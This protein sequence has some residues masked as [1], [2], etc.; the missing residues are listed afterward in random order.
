MSQL[1]AETRAD[2][3][4]LGIGLIL[5]AFLCFAAVDTSVKWL[6]LVGLPAMQL[7]FMRYLVAF[8]LSV[9]R[10]LQQG[11]VFEWQ[12]WR[13]M[14]LVLLRGALLVLATAF[15]F[16]ALGYLPLSV[17]SSILNSAP[18]I[19]TALAVP[20]LG[21]RVG[22]FRWAAVLIGFIGVLI[23]IRPF[24]AAFH[25]ATLLMVVNAVAMAFFAILTRLLSGQI[26][27]QTMQVYMG[28]LGTGVLLVPALLTWQAPANSFEW[29]LLIAVGGFAW[30]GHE[31]YGRAH[32]FAEASVLIPFNYS[33][34]V[35]LTIAGVIVFGDVPDAPVL[36]GAAIIIGSGLVIWWRETRNAQGRDL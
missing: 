35:Y 16:I 32:A 1:V 19:L 15:N 27:T 36:I 20:L 9:G 17:T 33:F 31:I 13:V 10:G 28:A 24:G 12:A 26:A 8:L 34:I 11:T 4:G 18:I 5:L 25:W 6:A 7:A 2:R 23:V 14:R 22:P 21:E 30:L 3:A 29:G